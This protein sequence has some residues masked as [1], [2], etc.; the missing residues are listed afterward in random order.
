MLPSLRKKKRNT[1]SPQIPLCAIHQQ[2]FQGC[3]NQCA[4]HCKQ[5]IMTADEEG[6]RAGWVWGGRLCNRI[7]LFKYNN[8]VLL[9][10]EPARQRLTGRMKTTSS[11]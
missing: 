10:G 2:L 5:F 4:L 1:D 6:G 11:N 7:D 9:H 8:R 3:E